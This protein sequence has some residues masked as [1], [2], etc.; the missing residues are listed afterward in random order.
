MERKLLGL[1]PESLITWHAKNKS[2]RRQKTVF[3]QTMAGRAMLKEKA[4]K[5][6]EDVVFGIYDHLHP[7]RA[8]MLKI[9]HITKEK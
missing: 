6:M 1:S 2:L 8:E 5:T 9:R 4:N 7:R 3:I